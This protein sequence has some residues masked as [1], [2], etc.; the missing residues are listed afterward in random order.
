M[1]TRLAAV[2]LMSLLLP[3]CGS[4]DDPGST[5]PPGAAATATSATTATD[6]GVV[7]IAPPPPKPETTPQQSSNGAPE[8]AAPTT[9]AEYTAALVD[10]SKKLD[11]EIDDAGKSGDS[12]GIA[13][14]L[15]RIVDT[16]DAWT[17]AGNAAGGATA[18]VAAAQT[19]R[20]AVESPLLLDEAHRQVAAARSALGG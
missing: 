7:T 20:T 1:R 8:G 15:D 12:T 5:A 2:L 19:A 14:V 9:E 16:Q 13:K 6:T 17:K 10:L 11:D 3:A 4:S 18:L